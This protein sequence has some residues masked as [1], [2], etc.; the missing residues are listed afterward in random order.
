MVWTCCGGFLSD[1]LVQLAGVPRLPAGLPL[2]WSFLLHVCM[3]GP[4]ISSLGF[5]CYAGGCSSVFCSQ[6]VDS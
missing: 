3:H 2:Y 6:S 5:E 1:A 4:L